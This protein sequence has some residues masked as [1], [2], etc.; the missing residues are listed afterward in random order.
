MKRSVSLLLWIV[1]CVSGVAGQGK[2]EEG[3]C[4]KQIREQYIR[5]LVV[6][7]REKSA[8]L[9]LLAAI[10][11]EAEV[12]DQN[13]VELYQRFPVQE[14]EVEVLVTGLKGDG[15]W[16]DI[17]YEDRKRSGWEPKKHA[18]RIL[19]LAKFYYGNRSQY[20]QQ[21]QDSLKEVIHR[22]LGFWFRRKFTCLNWW[23]N[24]IGV[25][26]TLGPAFLLLE[27]ELTPQEKAA[28]IREMEYSRFGMT[29][30]NKVW[31]A[32]NVLIR[33]LLQDDYALVKAARDTIVSE[34]VLGQ[35]EGIQSD[36]SFHQHGPQQQ[37][38]NYGLS[39]LSN[40]CTYVE[41]FADTPLAFNE[42]QRWILFSFFQEGYRWFVWRGYMEVN[43]LNRQLFHNADVHK[44]YTL[45]FAVYSL[46][47]GSSTEQA[48]EIREFIQAN[49]WHPTAKNKWCGNKVFRDSDQT[50][51]RTSCWMASVKMA[52]T[53][54][55]GTELV[56]EDNKLGYYLADGAMYVYV[57]GDEY[58]NI[59]PFWDWRKIPGITSVESV[60]PIPVR[61]GV[62]SRNRSAF[63]GGVTD[64]RTGITAMM[65][66][67][68]GV[69]ANK[70][71]IFTDDFILCLGSD[72]Q[73]DSSVLTTSLEQCLKAGDVMVARD[74]E[75]WR[76]G[77]CQYRRAEW[78]VRFHHGNTGYI[79]LQ[80]DTCI[81][82]VSRRSGR[83]FDVMG[84]YKPQLIDQEIVSLYIKH[85]KD[86]PSTY[87]YLVL[88]AKTLKEVMSFKTDQ[89]RV[90]RNDREVQAVVYDDKC[91]I[92][93]YRTCRVSLPDQ[94]EVVVNTPGLYLIDFKEK[95]K[96]VVFATDPTRTGKKLQLVVNGA[97]IDLMVN[98]EETA[99]FGR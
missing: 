64:G 38:G 14:S 1:F 68:H 82:T 45:L 22:S 95:K 99:V 32:G 69:K 41:L 27:D 17:N 11:P 62:D 9:K 3:A 12:S 87:Q 74:G 76:K 60:A 21:K 77:I 4:L 33:G 63:V 83:W 31:L 52:S 94:R 25:P 53:R 29:G 89:L 93:A 75:S 86:C 98:A 7:D 54:V 42:E 73:G 84:M 47:Q 80:A 58:H 50:I 23:Y 37:M 90:V 2:S 48:R 18:E 49:F 5:S 13:I 30:Q 40:M 24:Q 78:P 96:P 34:V 6:V 8:C 67:R 43:G 88:P 72:I 16:P 35:P 66:Q 57:D 55:I 81:S 15:S 39:F 51:H 10:P 65:L 46:M 20:P 26:R 44:A 36:W 19:K 97:E 59:Y 91:Y 92:A 28:A 79:V 85:R 56:N 71:W 61:Y 70:S